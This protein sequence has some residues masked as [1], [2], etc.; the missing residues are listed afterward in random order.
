MSL[1]GRKSRLCCKIC[2][3]T[4]NI[5]MLL[6]HFFHG[7]DVKMVQA[8][9]NKIFRGKIFANAQNRR[10]KYLANEREKILYEYE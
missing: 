9:I 3:R 1:N 5:G 10:K 7:R 4:V 6:A 2:L 8:E